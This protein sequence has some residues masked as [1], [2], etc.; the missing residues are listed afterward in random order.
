MWTHEVNLC[1]MDNTKNSFN[2]TKNLF[3]LWFGRT[4]STRT[5]QSD[6]QQ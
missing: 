2:E 3:F 6:H 1:L 5:T 4:I